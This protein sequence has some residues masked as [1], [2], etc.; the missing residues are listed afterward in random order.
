MDKL[1]YQKMELESIGQD[2]Y[3]APG[4]KPVQVS[5]FLNEQE[6]EKGSVCGARARVLARMRAC[7]YV[8]AYIYAYIYM[9]T[10]THTAREREREREVAPAKSVPYLACVCV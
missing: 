10:H 9:H 8:R 7:V 4:A 6:R 2:A 5:V 1:Q 3:F